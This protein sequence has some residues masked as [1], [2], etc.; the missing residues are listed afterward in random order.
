MCAALKDS[1]Q[2][3]F[4]IDE[5]SI[6][7]THVTEKSCSTAPSLHCQSMDLLE[8]NTQEVSSGKVLRFTAA[9]KIPK[10][11]T[12]KP[13]AFGLGSEGGTTRTEEGTRPPA[14]TTLTFKRRK[15]NPDVNAIRDK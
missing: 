8:M 11:R 2:N 7:E 13:G 9:R 10:M 3:E 4:E 14:K 1:A 15:T 12:Q 6:Q 5:A